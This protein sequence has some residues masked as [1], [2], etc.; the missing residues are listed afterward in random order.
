M[1]IGLDS[2]TT[3]T[4][5]VDGVV[6][7]ARAA[8]AAGLASFWVPNHFGLDALTSLAVVGREQPDLE[9]GTAVVPIYTRHPFAMAQQAMTVQAIV[10]GRLTLGIG[11]SHRPIVEG[12]WGLPFEHPARTM[13][14]YLSALAAFTGGGTDDAPPLATPDRPTP[15]RVPGATPLPVVVA[16]LGPRM[17]QIAGALADG[18]VL[19]SVGKSGIASIVTALRAAARDANRP[20][21]RVVATLPVCVTDDVAAAKERIHRRIGSVSELPSYQR[22]LDLEGAS[23]VADIS[24]VGDEGTVLGALS[25]FEDVGVTEFAAMVMGSRDE[26]GATMDALARLAAS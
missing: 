17:V 18:V 10:G 5:T 6:A 20:A 13:R 2:T 12:A 23:N 9:L 24:L 1:K 21:P 4:G 25:Q 19:W 8:A 16:A 22:S 15:P 26:R 7:E 14:E 11:L 3:N